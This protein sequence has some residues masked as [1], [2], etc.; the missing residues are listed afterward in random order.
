MK[1][2]APCRSRAAVAT[3]YPAWI[4]HISWQ[5]RG[6]QSSRQFILR[7]KSVSAQLYSPQAL[8][9]S[10]LVKDNE[11]RYDENDALRQI[12]TAKTFVD[13]TTEN[14]YRYTVSLYR[15]DDIAGQ[16]DGLYTLNPAAVPFV[17][18]QIENPDMLPTVSEQAAD[19]RDPG[20][21][22]SVTE[23]FND[24]TTGAWTLSEADGRADNR[25]QRTGCR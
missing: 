4:F 11:V 16:V 18:F 17:S 5:N 7:S 21:D 8:Y 15:P 13:I 10:S 12:L 9:L 23:Y 3:G 24:E 14:E 19:Y 1:A 20:S 2:I 25:T 22:S 6:R